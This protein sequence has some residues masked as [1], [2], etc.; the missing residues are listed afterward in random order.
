M[1]NKAKIVFVASVVAASLASPVFAQSSNPTGSPLPYYYGSDGG[2]V[3]GS[4]AP[5]TTQT[6][7]TYHQAATRSRG[8]RALA[9]TPRANR[10]K[11]AGAGQR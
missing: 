1:A 6:T 3:R 4:W 2:Q 5:E 8:L 10:S 11:F 9:M 7:A